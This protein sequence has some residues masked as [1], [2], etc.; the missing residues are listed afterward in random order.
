MKKLNCILLVDDN[1]DDNFFHTI[2][3]NDTDAS[4]QVKTATT[5]EKAIAYL[6]KCKQGNADCP[7][8][9][10]VF[11][12]INM[13]GMNGFEFLEEARSRK[14][15]SADKP[16]IVVMLTSSLNPNDEKMAREKFG[17]EIKDYQNKPLTAEMLKGI[18]NKYF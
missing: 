4:V 11:L 9:D 16:I 8:P 6:E 18:I 12:D 7:M 14:L 17:S 3:I 2:I 10:L 15:I 5:G 1:V 13:P